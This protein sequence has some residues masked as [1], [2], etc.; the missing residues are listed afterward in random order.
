[1]KKVDNSNDD[2][3]LTYRLPASGYT[4]ISIPTILPGRHYTIGKVLD[5][6]TVPVLT[7]LKSGKSVEK[8]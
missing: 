7:V 1:M 4:G 8:L 3:T 2:K 5:H 6:F